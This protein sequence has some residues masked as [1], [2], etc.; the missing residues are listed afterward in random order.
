MHLKHLYIVNDEDHSVWKWNFGE[1]FSW[2]KIGEDAK[3]IFV[4]ESMVFKKN[5]GD[6]KTYQWSLKPD[7]WFEHNMWF[8]D[9]EMN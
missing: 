3:Y 9:E 7:E 1:P 8:F 5:R 4:V 6:R 2:E